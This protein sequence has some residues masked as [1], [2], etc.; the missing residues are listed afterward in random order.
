MNLHVLVSTVR[1]YVCL[2]GNTIFSKRTNKSQSASNESKI[3]HGYH[4]E[5][6]SGNNNQSTDELIT[7]T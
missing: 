5:Q 4:N 1:M 7:R 3:K 2:T 6:Q